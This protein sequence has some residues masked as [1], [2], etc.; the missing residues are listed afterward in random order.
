MLYDIRKSLQWRLLLNIFLLTLFPLPSMLS[1]EYPLSRKSYSN[2]LCYSSLSTVISCSISL[3]VRTRMEIHPFTAAFV[4]WWEPCASLEA[5]GRNLFEVEKAG[6]TPPW[7]AQGG[8]ICTHALPSLQKPFRGTRPSTCTTVR[9]QRQVPV[10]AS[11]TGTCC[12]DLPP[13]CAASVLLSLTNL[14][15]FAPDS[16]SA[17]DGGNTQVFTLFIWMV[18]FCK[19]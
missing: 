9:A 14:S 16:H 15:S 5:D 1:P 12:R 18:P 2:W 6:S 11:G 17:A 3:V 10:L 7:D 4:F 19:C 13:W 8:L